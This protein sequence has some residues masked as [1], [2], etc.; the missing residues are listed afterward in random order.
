MKRVHGI[1]GCVSLVGSVVLGVLAGVPA[2]AGQA[3]PPVMKQV[4]PGLY[5]DFDGTASNSI[6]WVTGE[7]VLVVDTKQ[8][9]RQAHGLI[10]RIRGITNKPIRWA[11]VTQA[12]G[13]HYL[14]NQVFK[15]EAAT[16]VSQAEV[17]R[18][19]RT[20]I[21]KEM[22]RRQAFF[23]RNQ[24]DPKEIHLTLPD[25]TFDKQMTIWLA[26]KAVHLIYMGAGQDP[27]NAF[28]YFPHAKALATGGGYVTR[29]RANP[30]FTPSVDGWIT[31]L[32]QIKAM[33]VDLYLPG[34][35]DVGKKQN[36]DEMIGYL[37]DLQ[38]GVKDA[39]SRGLTKEAAVQ[40]LAFPQ[41]KDWRN[42]HLAPAQIGA[43]Y[44]LLTTGKSI[45]LD[46]E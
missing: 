19:M 14:G 40:S 1:F 30:M 25:V 37:T 35:G 20:Y 13:D 38:A 10:A 3:S 44:H 11:F 8:H 34:H 18:L 28:A 46:R 31:I 17:P 29:S 16:I 33:D 45:Y 39:I 7:G 36:V 5:F 27:G 6:I 15:K 23:A 21:D 24:F 41:Y 42:A 22:A 43:T 26:G 12:H 9:P 2:E 32:H 4:A